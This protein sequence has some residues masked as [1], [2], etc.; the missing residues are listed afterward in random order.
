MIHPSTELRFINNEIGYGV[1]ATELIPKG[2]VTWALDRLDREFTGSELMQYEEIYQQ[3][4]S[5]YCFRNKAGK[6]ILCWDN[7]RFVNHSFRSNCL[8]T[9]YEFEI[10]VRDI[11]PDEELTDDYGYLNLTQPFRGK[12]EKS[13]RKYVYPDDLV[14]YHRPWDKKLLAAFK[15]IARVEQPLRELLPAET[16]ERCCKIARG[17]EQMESI[18]G[19]YYDSSRG[20]ETNAPE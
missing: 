3:I 19:I 16:W 17:E 12:D 20:D 9:A 11:Q 10:A 5:K 4:L 13:R 2:T 6:F 14:K 15:H 8:A 1:V 18:L 7:G